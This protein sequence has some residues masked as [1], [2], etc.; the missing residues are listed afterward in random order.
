MGRLL[1]DRRSFLKSALATGAYLAATGGLAARPAFAADGFAFAA[2]GESVRRLPPLN[3]SRERIIRTVVGLR[4]YRAEGFVLAPERVGEKVVVHNY[5]HGGA[6]MTLSWGVATLAAEQARNLEDLSVAVIGCGIIGLST[7]RVLQRRGK[8]VTVYA[9]E[10]PPET[11]S[12]LAGAL[13]YPTSV[14]DTQKISADFNERFRLACRLSNREFQTYV[15]PDYGVRWIE[16]Y[17]L[18]ADAE[19]AG[20]EPA[21]GAELYPATHYFTDARRAFGFPFV[22][23]FSTMLIEPHTYLRALM[24]DF[25]TAGGRIVVR[26][27]KSRED[28][29]S[30]PERVVFNCTGLGAKALFGDQQLT[31]VRGQIEMLL[32]Q[33]ELDYCY[34]ANSLYMFPRRDGIVLGGTFEP[35]NYSLEPD[36]KTTARIVEGHAEIVKGFRH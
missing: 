15:G 2:D 9:R 27:L 11:T 1:T 7:A 34:L 17:T 33:P 18:R 26:E 23:L 30:L 28:V 20:H 10:M 16:T 21:G 36:A 25:H 6:G 4:P 19:P 13:W 32:P 29:A 24:R 35:D 12:N 31:P 22:R 14:Y 3:V 8:S 5:G